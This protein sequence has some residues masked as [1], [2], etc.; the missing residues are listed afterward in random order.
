[1]ELKQDFLEK[2]VGELR[3]LLAYADADLTVE[4]WFDSEDFFEDEDE[5]EDD[6][7]L[8]D[9]EDDEDVIDTPL[10]NIEEEN[11]AIAIANDINNSK[12]TISTI[13]GVYSSAIINRVKYM[14]D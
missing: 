7:F 4:N 9:E 6:F 12:Y 5:D 11:L 13:E 1:M 2:S 10:S 8:D 14:I 3:E